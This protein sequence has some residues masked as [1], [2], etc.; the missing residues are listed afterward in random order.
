MIVQQ[1]VKM[2]KTT[3]TSNVKLVEV[4]VRAG[5]LEQELMCWLAET[6]SQEGSS[7]R[8]SRYLNHRGRGKSP[9]VWFVC[10]GE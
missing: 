10:M 7:W 4:E 3:S 1:E 9:E 8:I 2:Q 5:S 6:G